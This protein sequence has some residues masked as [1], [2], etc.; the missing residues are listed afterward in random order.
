MREVLGSGKGQ[1]GSELNPEYLVKGG[2]GMTHP[3]SGLRCMRSPS[4]SHEVNTSYKMANKIY[5]N[6]EDPADLITCEYHNYIVQ[7][8][9]IFQ[10]FTRKISGET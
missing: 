6:N 2:L 4:P 7:I 8:R 1:T 5:H 10:L 9:I 3:I